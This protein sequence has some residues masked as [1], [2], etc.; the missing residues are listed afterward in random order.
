MQHESPL[1]RT[2]PPSLGTKPQHLLPV[3]A[4]VVQELSP[5]HRRAE[6]KTCICSLPSEQ[7]KESWAAELLR[8]ASLFIDF[9]VDKYCFNI[10]T[11]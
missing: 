2:G 1:T 3:G 6:R 8:P 4:I 5:C 10:F 11:G 9:A 7:I